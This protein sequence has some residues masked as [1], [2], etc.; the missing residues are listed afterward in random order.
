[1]IPVILFFYLNRGTVTK[2]PVKIVPVMALN[3]LIQLIAKHSFTIPL[4]KPKIFSIVFYINL[5]AE[6]AKG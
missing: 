4:L 2:S 6:V 1:V 5:G 3:S